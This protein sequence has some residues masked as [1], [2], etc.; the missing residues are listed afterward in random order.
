VKANS[1][2]KVLAKLPA[3]KVV[4]HNTGLHLY[5]NQLGHSLV[6]FGLFKRSNCQLTYKKKW[7]NQKDAL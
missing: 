3:Q 1:Y 7:T 4:G 2:W 5:D 6:F